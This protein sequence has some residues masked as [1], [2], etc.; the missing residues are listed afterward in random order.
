MRSRYAA[1]L[2]IC[3]LS[4]LLS[5]SLVSNG[6]DIG[7]FSLFFVNPYA[8]NPSYAGVEGRPALFFAHKRQ[9]VGIDAGP[10]ISNLSLHTPL[11]SYFSF[12]T[13]ISTD[14]R[15]LFNTTGALVSGAYT[16][17][18]GDFKSMRFGISAG[19]GWNRLDLSKVT[20]TDD[21]ELVRQ[22]KNSF[23]QGSAGVSFHIKSFHGG[24]ALPHLFETVHGATEG[25]STLNPLQSVMVHASNRFYFDRGKH[26]LEP[27]LVYRYSNVSSSQL[28]AAVVYHMNNILWLGGAY[29]QSFGNSAFLGFHFNKTLGLGYSYTFKTGDLNTLQSPSHELQLTLLLGEKR[30]DLPFFSFV[31]TDKEK[32]VR[33]HRSVPSRQQQALAKNQQRPTTTTQ[34]QNNTTAPVKP[35][36]QTVI[37]KN[38]P[39]KKEVPVKKPE[40]QPVN[41]KPV[42]DPDHPV[43]AEINREPLHKPAIEPKSIGE[44]P[45]VHDTLHPLHEEEKEKVSRLEVHADDP[46]EHHEDE[47][48]PHHPE[49]HEFVKRGDHHHELHIGDYVIAGV[50]RSDINADH[51][52]DGLVKLGFHADYGHLTAK[53]LWYVFI[54]HS[55]NLEETRA[56]AAKFRKMKIFKDAWILTVHH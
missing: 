12:G 32:R 34:P 44:L 25:G 5:H 56:A 4:F 35:Q 9:W 54:Y 30:R 8:Y 50:F 14:K 6:Q 15:G 40:E 11:Q 13:S 45:H 10:Q 37:A 55:E 24:I 16:V 17:M 31:D 47:N 27:H 18:L 52:A 3:V 46:D 49:R 38:E 23:L 20:D 42:I 51:F 39:V 22:D 21:P 29:K 1:T 48:H 36:Q 2:R 43:Y 41:Q 53:N 26:V 33:H 19:G 7:N 28:E